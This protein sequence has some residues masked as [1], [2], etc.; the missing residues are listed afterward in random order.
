MRDD[1]P[2]KWNYREHT[3]VKHELL[4]K[5]LSGWL[6][7]L[8]RWH[9]RLL[10]VDGFAGR[11]T[12]SDGSDGSP[13]IIL[14]K[15]QEL[16][17]IRRVGEVF[18]AFVE[19]NPK[20]Y[21]TLRT[22]LGETKSAH[23]DVTIL[24]PF[25]DKFESVAARAVRDSGGKLVPSFWFID[26]FGFTGISLGMMKRIMALDRSEVFIT[27]M[28]RDINR[29]LSHVDLHDALDR[30]FGTQE[31]RRIRES[32]LG[33]HEQERALLQLYVEQLRSIGCKVTAFRVCMDDRVQT[34][35]YM[36]HGT[37]S[38][39]GRRLMK[40][41]MYKQGAN[42]LF[43]YLGPREQAA[44]MQGMLIEEDPIPAL[45]DQ[46]LSKYGGRRV[47][48]ED[49]CNECCDDNDLPDR[50]YRDALKGLREEGM[51]VVTP[52]TSKTNRGLGGDDL[53]TFP[54][55]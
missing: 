33:G 7:I 18:C 27:W 41:V 29:F 48:F 20:N 23:P 28:V 51:V 30:L 1:D 8:G 39:K 13:I 47:S 16:I 9:K 10:I 22:L 19:D 53:I 2:A 6:S 5:Y 42:G 35:Y 54:S 45:K 3:K 43:R 25:N 37:K 49:I 38:P 12:Y 52:V 32:S 50:K 44:Q 55:R 17:S 14:R 21:A 24:G 34:L 4:E 11:G 31:W 40:D 15:A 36:M 46:L 26:P